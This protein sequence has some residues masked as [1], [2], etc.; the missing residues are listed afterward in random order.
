MAQTFANVCTEQTAKERHTGLSRE[1]L[2]QP[3][4]CDSYT[5]GGRFRLGVL[6]ILA[7]Y[8][9]AGDHLPN[10]K[11]CPPASGKPLTPTTEGTGERE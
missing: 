8:H 10:R 6:G 11:P 5:L 7:F 9:I 3:H 2:D 1:H 4:V